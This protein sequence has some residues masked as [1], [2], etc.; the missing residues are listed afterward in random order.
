MQNGIF[1]T[2]ENMNKTVDSY[3][4]SHKDEMV[5]SVQE[6]IS[7]PSVEAA[8]AGEGA[9]FGTAV[10]D[11]LVSALK[12]SERL[13]L[14]TTNY[15]GYAGAID[16]GEG[17]EMLGIICHVDVV[18]EGEGWTHPPYGGVI[19]NGKIYGRGTIDDK[20]PAICAIYG[21]A[22]VKAANIPLKRRVRIILGTNEETGWGGMHHYMKVAEIP[23]FSFTPDGEYPIVNSEKGIYHNTVRCNVKTNIRINGGT[24][25]NVVCGKTRVFVP[26]EIAEIKKHTD[27]IAAKGFGTDFKEVPDGTEIVITGLDAHGSM[28]ERGK[29]A[30]LAAFALLDK[31]PL[32][33]EDK[34]V[35]SVLHDK[36]KFDVHGESIGL[37][38]EDA[39]GR[40]SLNPG[41][42]KWDENGFEIS[43]DVRHPISMDYKKVKAGIMESLKELNPEC[44]TES[45]QDGHY[46]A[47]D[48]ELVSKLLKVYEAR[49]GKHGEPLAIGGG[50][51]ARAFPNAVAFGCSQDGI[52]GPEHMPDEFI[53]VDEVVFNAK[54][55]A[56]AII[57]LAAE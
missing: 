11:S 45:K 50:T 46:I 49:S 33:G 16:Y 43:F 42:I 30:M 5:R 14:K 25:P 52:S 1:G 39:S 21:L 53:G 20:G 4:D 6:I 37:D 44:I 19:D 28:P 51:Y 54:M 17:K 9:P 2:G 48:T 22:A 7:F 10:R 12:L 57:A 27:E 35:V 56:D 3:I 55:I 18:P 23:T 8:P 32:T 15:D 31:L 40:L 47:P 38:S 36:Y 24:R 29:N 41:V 34:R 26:V 13:G